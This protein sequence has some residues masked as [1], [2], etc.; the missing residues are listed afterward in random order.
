MSGIEA[1]HIFDEHNNVL[2]SHIFTSRP[3]PASQLISSYLSHPAPRPSLIH[4]PNLNPPTLLHSLQTDS[5]LLLSPTSID[6]PPLLVLEFLHR[7]SDALSEFLGSPLLASRIEAN[8]DIAAQVLSELCDAGLVAGTE[9]NALRD[10]VETPS[11][12]SRFLG[13]VGLTGQSPTLAVGGGS[14]MPGMGSSSSSSTISQSQTSIPWRRA[15]VR[16]TSNELYVD[17]VETVSATFAP[18]GRAL[19]A[20]ANGTIAFTSKVSGVPDLLLTLTTTSLGSSAGRG[21]RVRSIMERPVFHPCV[22]LAR[23]TQHGEL[24]FVPPDGRFVLAGYEA[25]LLPAA[26]ESIL[27]PDA[28]RLNL[29]VAA[30]MTTGLGP[31]GN[32]FEVRLELAPKFAGAGSAGGSRGTSPHPAGPRVGPRGVAA[33]VTSGL[34]SE[35]KAPALEDLR[36]FIPLPAATV[37]RV[38]DLRPSRGEAH[39]APAEGGIVWT[40]SPKV[41]GQMTTATLRGSVVGHDA[42]AES[43]SPLDAGG[44]YA[45]D[46]E[47]EGGYQRGRRKGDVTPSEAEGQGDARRKAVNA[48]L[49]PRCVSISFAAKGWLASG[50]RVDSLTVDTK[51]SRGLG[52]T[53]KP[54]KGVKYLT[55]SR[56]GVEV[57][58]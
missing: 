13:N 56:G 10:V 11:S 58:C 39:F 44:Q 20:F 30:R 53:V 31:T 49:M 42:G 19:S 35:T 17:L 4:L 40:F 1:L 41:V 52:E 43:E 12:L 57:R 38:P 37:R 24:S 22:R 45:Y 15:N 7:V 21:H 2:L 25:D 33:V 55:V 47:A 18:S 54:Y 51:R 16:H 26:S 23:W 6:V 28:H 3:P 50:L 29:P 32:E 48:A 27:G 5:L 9:A 14:G 46:A 36:A 34:T 8:Y